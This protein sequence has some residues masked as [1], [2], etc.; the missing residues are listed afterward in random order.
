MITVTGLAFSRAHSESGLVK[1][2]LTSESDVEAFLNKTNP[3]AIIHCAAER[4]P[5]VVEKDPDASEAINVAV[6]THLAKWCAGK[7]EAK[8]P[9]LINISTDYVFDGSRPPYKVDDDP[10]PL[11][12]YGVSKLR[13]ERAVA[14]HGPKGKT[15][16]LRVPVL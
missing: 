1:L 12:A 15:V 8:Q 6:P 16:N 14:E 5:D 3:N 7:E 11:N 2:D 13:G 4:R 9:L 10:K